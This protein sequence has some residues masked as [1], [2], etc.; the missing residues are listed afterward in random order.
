MWPRGLWRVSKLIP[1]GDLI[2]NLHNLCILLLNTSHT[3]T[4]EME[5]SQNTLRS[6]AQALLTLMG[7]QD[8]ADKENPPLG[9]AMRLVTLTQKTDYSQPAHRLLQA[10]LEHSPS[11]ETV[12]E[13]FMTELAK[14]EIPAVVELGDAASTLCDPFYVK[15]CAQVGKLDS[16]RAVSPVDWAANVNKKLNE[17]DEDMSES[18]LTD[19]ANYYLNNLVIACRVQ[20]NIFCW[21]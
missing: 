20:F 9:W 16:D 13:Q 1:L 3:S 18:S 2:Y 5:S 8:G 14:C 21:P 10:L 4:M 7:N 12:A 6:Y 19:L 11:P 17:N 15:Y